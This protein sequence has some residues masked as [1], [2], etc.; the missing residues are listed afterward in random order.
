MAST[1]LATGGGGG[2]AVVG[3]KASDLSDLIFKATCYL[4]P[5][6][7]WEKKVM[8]ESGNYDLNNQYNK[9]LNYCMKQYIMLDDGDIEESI[10][11]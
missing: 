4:W 2:E 10:L 11:V 3:L 1:T 7:D 8:Q 9:N 6:D 5:R